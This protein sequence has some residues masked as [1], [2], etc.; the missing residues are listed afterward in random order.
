LSKRFIAGKQDDDFM[1][2][3]LREALRGRGHTSPNPLV[4]AVIVKGGR[5]IARG[6]HAYF[7]GP[8]SEIVA[9][10][11]L[12]KDQARG[13]TLYV[14]LEPCCCYGKTPPCTDA[15]IAAR[16]RRVVIGC[17]DPNPLV[18]G[19][20]IAALRASG[21]EVTTGVLEDQAQ[22]LNAPYLTFVTQKRPW[23][24]L[25]MAQTLDGRLALAS[26]KSRWITGQEAR[27]EAHR[28]RSFLDT[29]LIG[30][31]TV[32]QDDPELT[33]RLVRGRN[34][35]RVILD[36]RLR[37]P[38]TARVLH[39]RDPEKTIIFTTEKASARKRNALQ[40]TG[41]QVFQVRASKEG[42]VDLRA[43]LRQMAQM[44]VQSLM[45]EG[46]GTVHRS[47]LR[48]G[49]ADRL[50]VTI[51]P[52]LIGADGIASVG[53]LGLRAIRAIPEFSWQRVR[54][55][56]SDLWLELDKCLPD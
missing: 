18:S 36:S 27:R 32:I 43:A 47:F 22:R 26:G 10:S 19:K 3:A 37:I 33:V 5:E 34:P 56:G 15:I 48:S 38:L 31:R 13:A 12:R 20:G 29:V 28:L 45:V 39:H 25:K 24:L 40:R 30:V 44:S 14:N 21:I 17:E 42:F 4:G 11:K 9:L 54:W 1:R 46:G 7:G 8:H 6:H 41:A 23:V 53:T 49:C 52:K 50:I 2:I 16:I 35:L 55:V 51:A